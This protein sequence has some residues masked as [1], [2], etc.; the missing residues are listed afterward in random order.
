MVVG[1]F[2]CPFVAAA[3][4]AVA[5]T[6][7]LIGTFLS[8]SSSELS[9]SELDS[10]LTAAGLAGVVTGVLEGVFVVGFSSS[11]LSKS[12]IDSFL[13]AAGFF[14]GAFAAA[15]AGVITGVFVAGF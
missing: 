3:V 7:L 15:L 2:A 8:V 6:G 5:A 4:R 12:E 10:F 11:E 1:V 9:S 14:A 13:T